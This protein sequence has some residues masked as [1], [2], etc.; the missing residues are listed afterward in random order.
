MEG[1]R[2]EVVA[3]LKDRDGALVRVSIKPVEMESCFCCGELLA[4]GSKYCDACGVRQAAAPS[5]Y[6]IYFTGTTV[7]IGKTGASAYFA[8][9]IDDVRIYNYARTP[10]QI[11][12]DYNGGAA[13]FK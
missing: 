10:E 13:H 6:P 4:K 5:P 3:I 1:Q 8:G 11:L 9:L 12:Q 7:Q 2:K